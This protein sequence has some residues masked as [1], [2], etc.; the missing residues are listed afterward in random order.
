[1]GI[2]LCILNDPANGAFEPGYY[3]SA[4]DYHLADI[5]YG[6]SEA[7]VAELAGQ[8]FDIFL[9]LCDGTAAEQR[10]GIE[11]V[12]ALAHH[13]LAYTGADEAFYDPSRFQMKEA[14]LAEGIDFPAAFL[15]E[16]PGALARQA[17]RLRYPLL[18]K[19][20][21]SSGS[22]GLLP[23][24]RV[25]TL[26]DLQRQVA[27]MMEKYQVSPL[28]EEFIEGR[29]FSVLVAENPDSS[30]SPVAFQPVEFTFPPGDSFK[31]EA[32]K[33]IR[34]E[35]MT[36]R[37]VTEAGLDA[38]LRDLA[39]RIFQRM[40]GCGYGRCDIRMDESGRLFLLEINPNCGIFYPPDG[41]GTADFILQ[42]DPRGH[43]GFID[44]IFAT[45]QN[46]KR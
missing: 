7:Q 19:H 42:F 31:H 21:N 22:I 12:R 4:C 24:S 8:G 6:R 33:W 25:E 20:P 37:P 29:E 32:L 13:Q 39:V 40:N 27:R 5:Y 15:V 16:G 9:N 1:M 45:A 3:F 18:V 10:P 23:E 11:V 2:R 46:R 17:N 43:Q 41:P 30:G 28:V 38:R 44:L 14:C 35:E 36:C 26:P 34:Y